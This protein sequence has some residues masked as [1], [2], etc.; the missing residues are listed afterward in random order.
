MREHNSHGIWIAVPWRARQQEKL[1]D[2]PVK[3]NVLAKDAP[4]GLR[5]ERIISTWV[6]IVA[7][8]SL[9]NSTFGTSTI[10][11]CGLFFQSTKKMQSTT[12]EI[13]SKQFT[14]R[15]EAKE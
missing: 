10:F 5:A 13:G 14:L 1:L 15:Q 6:S 12:L 4:H 11:F 8:Q 7:E 3:L 2:I 9:F